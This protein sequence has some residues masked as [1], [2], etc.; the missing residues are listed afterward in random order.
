[1]EYARNSV[2][3][4]CGVGNVRR[5]I[6]FLVVEDRW[7]DRL[8]ILH[9]EPRLA[10]LPSVHGACSPEHLR[11]LV[12]HWMAT[13]SLDHPF[14]RVATGFGISA[15]ER[16]RTRV[17]LPEVQSGKQIGELAVHRESLQRVLHEQPEMLQC[18]LDALVGALQREMRRQ[19]ENDGIWS[20]SGN[21][22]ELKRA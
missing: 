11:Q 19:P 14:A 7:P 13:G 16:R 3:T 5:P 17:A 10:C 18:I 20:F 12:V 9:W 21:K 8:K 22:E 1:M 4:I 6:Q 15:S 2:C